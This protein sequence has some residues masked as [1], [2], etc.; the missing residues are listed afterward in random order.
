MIQVRIWQVV[1][2]MWRGAKE[3]SREL[4]AYV[5]N[6]IAFRQNEESYCVTITQRH[7]N[8][9]FVSG[10]SETIVVP[11]GNNAPMKATK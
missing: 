6:A 1:A 5:V 2:G 9:N 10:K 7:F 3:F 4:C 11:S 8:L